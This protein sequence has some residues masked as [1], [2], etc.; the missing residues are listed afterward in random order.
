MGPPCAM[1]WPH[2]PSN[3]PQACLQP[4]T[5]QRA[6]LESCSL[7]AAVRRLAG[8]LALRGVGAPPACCGLHPR[9][10]CVEDA[11]LLATRSGSQWW[12]SQW[13]WLAGACGTRSRR[14]AGPH[15]A[16]PPE[17]GRTYDVPPRAARH[18]LSR[19]SSTVS[20]V[21]CLVVLLLVCV[22]ASL[23]GASL[24]AQLRRADIE[25][26]VNKRGI[27]DPLYLSMP[28][29]PRAAPRRARPARAR[30]GGWRAS[31]LSL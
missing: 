8:A 22:C 9:R 30:L 11:R 24:C 13:A 17:H 16:L 28:L 14:G 4:G 19:A 25:Q 15:C 7:P 21:L 10:P 29:A 12:S 3:R 27:Y 23:K 1:R 31:P 5:R 18:A 6:P 26:F 2:G 20:C